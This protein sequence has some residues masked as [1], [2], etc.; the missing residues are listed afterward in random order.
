MIFVSENPQ[1][2]L[3]TNSLGFNLSF[4]ITWIHLFVT[5][6]C[7]IAILFFNYLCVRL[8]EII[9]LLQSLEFY[10]LF[11]HIS[12]W[13][14]NHDMWKLISKILLG[15]FGT[16]ILVGWCWNVDAGILM[17]EFLYVDADVEVFQVEMLMRKC[18]LTKICPKLPVIE[19][20]LRAYC[21]TKLSEYYTKGN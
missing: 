7:L 3:I 4:F 21:L 5:F 1:K 19:T 12:C 2:R 8:I 9:E 20:C 15:N 11:S 10:P 18:F 14:A 17:S 13:W 16:G 6:K